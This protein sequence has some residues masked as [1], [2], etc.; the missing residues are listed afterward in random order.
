MWH[1]VLL[2]LGTAFATASWTQAQIVA[3]T[4]I[5]RD[6]CVALDAAAKPPSRSVKL[7]IARAPLPGDADNVT[8]DARVSVNVR[9]LHR[10]AVQTPDVQRGQQAIGRDRRQISPKDQKTLALVIGCKTD[11]FE[12]V[13]YRMHLGTLELMLPLA[14]DTPTP[15]DISVCGLTRE[16]PRCLYGTLLD[17]SDDAVLLE[18]PPG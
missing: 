7:T 5:D 8:A 16:G 10:F 14:A 1:V 17:P 12:Y 6:Q 11:K 3:P 15:L 13:S 18:L 4:T 9:M 2:I